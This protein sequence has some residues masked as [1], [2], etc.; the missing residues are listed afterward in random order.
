MP[1]LKAYF[2]KLKT[3]IDLNNIENLVGWLYQILVVL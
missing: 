2:Y 1:L 3:N